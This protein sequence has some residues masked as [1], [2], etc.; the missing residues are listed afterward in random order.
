VRIAW[1]RH[2]ADAFFGPTSR[3]WDGRPVGC[4]PDVHGDDRRA[5]LAQFHDAEMVVAPSFKTEGKVYQL[6][7]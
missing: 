3:G 1:R 6:A 4:D 5:D 2:D 7:G